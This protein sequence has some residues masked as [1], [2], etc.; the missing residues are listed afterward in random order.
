MPL[1][2]HRIRYWRGPH[3]PLEVSMA[4]RNR[5][6]YSNP[7][8]LLRCHPK[9]I[10]RP[11]QSLKTD[12][13]ELAQTPLMRQLPEPF[14][15]EGGIRLP[16]YRVMR[17]QARFAQAHCVP[18]IESIESNAMGLALMEEGRDCHLSGSSEK[19]CELHIDLCPVIA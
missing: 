19:V 6:P 16:R 12:P 13:K 4:A 7:G 15:A 17:Q 11:I 8:N 14:L 3:I 2:T 18:S 5:Y 10:E 9:A 1:T